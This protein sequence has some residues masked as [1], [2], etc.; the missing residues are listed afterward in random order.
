PVALATEAPTHR[1]ELLAWSTD[2][3]TGLVRET[4]T[5]PNGGGERALRLISKRSPSRVV[6]SQ[7]NDPDS[8][9]PQKVSDAACARRLRSFGKT[10]VKRG[11]TD[12][13]VALTCADRAALVTVGKAH[14]AK[15]ADTWFTGEGTNLSRNELSIRIRDNVLELRAN[16]Q[17]IG[18]W[19]DIPQ[20]LE[21]RAALSPAGSLLVVFHGWEPA[22][23]GLMA[24]L[25]SKTGAAKDLAPTRL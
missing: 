15:I 8:K 5:T 7:I 11:F 19:P 4:S 24:V 9:R 10:L 17:A 25:S 21:M 22:N 1:A 2:G 14:S 12:V 16:D 23:S 20:P 13:S 18:A 3:L 6:L